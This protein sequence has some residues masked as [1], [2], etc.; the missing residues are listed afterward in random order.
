[1]E[2][3][4]TH[5]EQLVETL[6]AHPSRPVRELDMLSLTERLC[7][8]E[9]FNAGKGG[10]VGDKTLAELFEE[11]VARTPDQI[12]LVYEEVTL[13]YKELNEQSNQLGDYLRR[14]YGTGAEDLIGICL[15]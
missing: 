4:C 15:E 11:Q 13:T 3:M 5:L 7:L 6:V 2:Q 1:M 10:N 9:G 12:A 14:E 8:V